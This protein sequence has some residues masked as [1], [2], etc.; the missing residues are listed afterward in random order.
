MAPTAPTVS[1]VKPVKKEKKANRAEKVKL[2]LKA[3]WDP[4][5]DSAKM[6]SKVIPESWV[7][8]VLR[9]LPVKMRIQQQALASFSQ[10]TF[11][12]DLK[13]G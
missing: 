9:V 10:L 8:T 4:Q 13:S 3:P 5:A 2:A 6:V 7:M 11:I 1:R 12:Q